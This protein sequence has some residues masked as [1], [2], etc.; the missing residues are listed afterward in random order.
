MWKK[1]VASLCRGGLQLQH[2]TKIE[3][4]SPQAEHPIWNAFCCSFRV[5]TSQKST[6]QKHFALLA[7]AHISRKY[8]LW[9][10]LQAPTLS[11]GGGTVFIKSFPPFEW[12]KLSGTVANSFRAGTCKFWTEWNI[13]TGLPTWTLRMGM[14]F[15]ALGD[16]RDARRNC[17]CCLAG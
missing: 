3:L 1:W 9:N 16:R 11:K 13:V 10:R 2:A 7:L 15:T 14:G 6:S 5:E 12:S 17:S 4:Y 8:V